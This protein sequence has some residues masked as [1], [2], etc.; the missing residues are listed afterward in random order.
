[1]RTTRSAANSTAAFIGLVAACSLAN[2]DIVATYGSPT[3]FSAKITGMPDLDQ[4]RDSLPAGGSMYCVPTCHTNLFAYAAN[5]GF[6]ELLPGPGNWQSQSNYPV[7]SVAIAFAGV[8]M[9]TDPAKGTTGSGA[10]KGT[11]QLI[12]NAGLKDKLCI[13]Q[14]YSS[15]PQQWVRVHDI[16]KQVALGGI[17][18][19]AYGRYNVTSF[20]SGIYRLE[21]NADGKLVRNGGHCITFESASPSGPFADY[22]L[23][24]R[25]PAKPNATDAMQSAF[26]SEYSDVFSLTFA[27]IC[28]DYF[29]ADTM[30]WDVSEQPGTIRLIDG[31]DVLRPSGALR[32][33]NVS[34]AIRLSLLTPASLGLTPMPVTITGPAT[35]LTDLAFGA[36]STDAYALV[37]TSLTGGATQ[38]RRVNLANG[39]QV[40]IGTLTGLRG[41]AVGRDGSVYAHDSTSV[42]AYRPD[43]SLA[44]SVT[45]AA[46]P[47]SVAYDDVRDRVVVLSVPRRTVTAYSKALVPVAELVIPAA[48]P[49]S[50]AGSV[51]VSPEDGSI[52]F[53]TSASNSLGRIGPG[54]TTPEVSLSAV[55]GVTAPQ[56]VACGDAGRVWITSQ[57]TVRAI[58]Q[59]GLGRWVQ[60]TSSPF[61]LLADQGPLAIMRSR[62]N[63][64]PALHAGPGWTDIASVEDSGLGRSIADCVADLNGDGIVNGADIGLLLA[65]WGRTRVDAVSV[66]F[67]Y[68]GNAAG[69]WASDLALVLGDG[70]HPTIGWGGYNSVLGAQVD[71]GRWPF[72]GSGSA[73]SGHYSATVQL[74]TGSTL[75]G[76]G[77]WSV[78]VGNGRNAAAAVQYRNVRVAPAGPGMPSLVT[79]PDQSPTGLQ[80]S[81]KSFAISGITGDLNA[82]G[83][84][85][86]ADLGVLLSAWGACAR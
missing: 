8:Q 11:V 59:D 80:S 19:L 31:A 50:G 20:A 39:D 46:A 37:N 68:V 51:A 62:T 28:C 38:L 22:G 16:A 5:H 21:V 58:A 18:T 6:A 57:G 45:P 49:V 84:V 66:S 34:N 2:G 3:S 83:Q 17:A 32:F 13:Q 47:S 56:R 52:Y 7:A 9:G 36:D 44:A 70:V 75:S 61:H 40:T 10:M 81:T 42:T 41:I 27:S 25:D 48:I 43:G 26:K 82:D 67:D 86:G 85:D 29:T 72:H 60:D 53:V 23:T 79:V 30:Y 14:V 55:D 65:N 15:G 73:A 74:P 64:D 63:F 1:M 69:S 35:G 12:A 54:M 33:T 77:P 4:L 24:V 78:T 71:A 76:A